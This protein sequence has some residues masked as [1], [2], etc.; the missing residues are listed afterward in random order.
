MRAIEIGAARLAFP[1]SLTRRAP[2]DDEQEFLDPAPQLGW[3]F[4]SAMFSSY[5]PSHVAFYVR[6][7]ALV[8]A[9]DGSASGARRRLQSRLRVKGIA[10]SASCRVAHAANGCRL[11][12]PAFNPTPMGW[13]ERC[14]VAAAGRGPR[15]A[16]VLRAARH[17]QEH[18]RRAGPALHPVVIRNRE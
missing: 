15:T 13:R 1:P 2:K 7:L 16:Q 11:D 6:D 10:F 3:G 18:P 5:Q 14:V 4:K 9:A 17:Q 12:D 8:L